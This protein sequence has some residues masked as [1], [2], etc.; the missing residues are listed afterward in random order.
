MER[1]EATTGL[2]WGEIDNPALSAPSGLSE[3]GSVRCTVAM[4]GWKSKKLHN[5]SQ[6]EFAEVF[7]KVAQACEKVEDWGASLT[8]TEQTGHIHSLADAVADQGCHQL[9]YS[10]MGSITICTY[11]CKLD[12][13]TKDSSHNLQD[14]RK[15]YY[16]NARIALLHLDEWHGAKWVC[17][18]SSSQVSESDYK[19]FRVG[20]PRASLPY[21]LTKPLTAVPRQMP[22]SPIL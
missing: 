9:I 22:R 18:P 13:S 7:T 20:F 16:H 15:S 8:V 10:E 12:E 19:R 14:E 3:I 4:R 17:Y 2:L 6:R 1:C 21:V 5:A 11:M